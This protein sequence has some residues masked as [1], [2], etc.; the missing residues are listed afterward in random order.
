MSDTEM[1]TPSHSH[2]TGATSKSNKPDTYNG[3]RN[4]L[5]YWLLQV[6]RYFHLEGDKIESDDQ[7]V[8]ATSFL[9]G[10][11]EKWA[12]PIIRRYMDA[13]NTDTDNKALVNDWDLFKTKMREVFSP[14]QEKVIAEQKIQQLR[15]TTSAADYTNEFQQCQVAIDWDDNALMRMYKQGLKPRVRQELMRSGGQ[16]ATLQDLMNEAIRIDNELYGLQLEERLFAQGMRAPG[17]TNV[18]AR[19]RQTPRRSYPNQGRQ[20]NYTPRIPG[21]YRT[22]GY[23]PMHLDNLNKGPSKPKF[24]GNKDGK[25]DITCYA[26][27]KKGHMKRDCRSQGK[28]VRQLNV[29]HRAVPDTSNDDEW[30]VIT[31]PTIRMDTDEIVE[32]L[33]DLTIITTEQPTSDEESTS[34]VEYFDDLE[35]TEIDQTKFGKM[36]SFQET[37]RPSTPYAPEEQF[38]TLSSQV[39]RLLNYLNKDRID[40]AYETPDIMAAMRQD[41]YQLSQQVEQDKENL[42]Q[43][44]QKFLPTTDELNWVNRAIKV[45]NDL[46]PES[47]HLTVQCPEDLEKKTNILLKQLGRPEVTFDENKSDYYSQFARYNQYVDLCDEL[48]A[49]GLH[50]EC[51]FQW[52]KDAEASWE[53]TPHELTYQ[54]RE[55]L[56][57]YLT[58]Q[59]DPSWA[60]IEDQEYASYKA[61]R[62]DAN[63]LEQP[64]WA[65]RAYKNWKEDQ[66]QKGE[67]NDSIRKCHSYGIYHPDETHYWMDYRNEKHA[68]MSWTA[69]LHQQCVIH[70]SDKQGAEYY[71]RKFNGMPKCKY[72]WFDCPKDTCAVHLWDKRHSPYFHGHEDPQETLQMH[73]TQQ[74]DHEDG[75]SAWE[76]NQPSWHTCL[77]IECD[78]HI[79]A[80]EFYGFGKQSF[81]DG[82]PIRVEPLRSSTA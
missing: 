78:L 44:I 45:H 79:V 7:V 46:T 50:P 37:H 15:Q 10:N 28:V 6:D 74:K 12:T 41:F 30:N 35:A 81:L 54:E 22:N 72:Q 70:Y 77:N 40:Y 49:Q 14:F 61:W 20:R 33:D 16:V 9:R 4:K 62:D 58:R 56:Y 19:A 63:I 2:A 69:C 27:G 80:K 38:K 31:R 36:M 34:E 18:N 42:P 8:W 25:K 23:E 68:N 3:E 59:C 47:E 5:E 24:Q 48:Q 53:E 39:N 73:I 64:E 57:E 66:I 13:D 29:I 71:P 52:A 65:R 75:T 32:G 43:D 11:A 17:N 51:L 21:A 67:H 76:C 1:D 26:C 82:R 55:E 60:H